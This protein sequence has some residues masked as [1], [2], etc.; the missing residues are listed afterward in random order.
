VPLPCCSVKVEQ[1]LLTGADQRKA[2]ILYNLL[3][4]QLR[5]GSGHTIKRAVGGF[6]KNGLLPVAL[7][8]LHPITAAA[9]GT[10][11]GGLS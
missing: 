10:M 2:D 5:R 7:P 3:Q 6:N 9:Y 11:S 4:S 1:V 8:N